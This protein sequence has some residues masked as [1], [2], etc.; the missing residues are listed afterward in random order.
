MKSNSLTKKL[1]SAALA[2]VMAVGASAMSVSAVDAG[3]INTDVESVLPLNGS[4]A[5]LTLNQT[6]DFP[7]YISSRTG[8]AYKI[9][10]SNNGVLTYKDGKITASAVGT[11]TVT[12]TLKN[13]KKLSFTF[14]VKA[15]EKEITLDQS[16]LSLKVGQS[17]KLSARLKNSSGKI[18]WKSS[19]TRIVSVDQNGKIKAHGS[20]TAVV[21]AATDNGVTASCQINV[22]D[23]IPVTAVNIHTHFITLP[24]GES[25]Q[26][27][28]SVSPE[29]A[30]NTQLK[31]TSLDT[32]VAAVSDGLVTA[33]AEGKTKIVFTS[34]NGL[35][36]EC[37]VIVT[38]PAN[39]PVRSVTV[40]KT[41]ITLKVGKS[42]KVNAAVSPSNATDK[43]LTY[44]IGNPKIAKVSNGIVTA[45]RAGRTKLT[46]KSSNGKKAVCIVNAVE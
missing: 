28:T 7:E 21:S 40:N 30:S 32:S 29:N 4:G 39:V 20:G 22:E 9:S 31:C 15:P 46:I 25:Y 14:N 13:G 17:S 11:G 8:T 2:V 19:D 10:V 41:E 35:S 43:T 33:K 34:A 27:R 5:T 37:D 42:M 1:F 38:K 3:T 12:I 23:P 36:S 45:K 24:V 44:T 18:I 16:K 26:L 6:Y